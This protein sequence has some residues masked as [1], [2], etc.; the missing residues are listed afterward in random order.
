MD[1][2]NWRVKRDPSEIPARD[3]GEKSPFQQRGWNTRGRGG[4]YEQ[5]SPPGGFGS[6]QSRDGFRKPV[7]NAQV[8]WWCRT[9]KYAI[10]NLP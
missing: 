8:S 5:R 1:S 3:Q 4:G 2:N 9:L 6:G 7:N 10:A